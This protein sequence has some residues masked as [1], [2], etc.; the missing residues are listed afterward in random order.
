MPTTP[1]SDLINCENGGQKHKFHAD[2]KIGGYLQPFY[3]FQGVVK[4]RA[5]DRQ[6]AHEVVEREGRA[7]AVGVIFS[8]AIRPAVMVAETRGV[9]EPNR[10]VGEG[11]GIL[12]HS[13][14]FV[15]AGQ[16]EVR[17]D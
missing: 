14:P 6:R 11:A 15:H 3:W 12:Q 1:L 13:N 9:N 8:E 4:E 16:P 5:K 17:N 2:K 7:I 10:T